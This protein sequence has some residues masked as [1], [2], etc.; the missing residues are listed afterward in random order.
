MP[1]AISHPFGPVWDVNSRVLVLGTFPSAASREQGFYYGHPRNR[2]WLVLA[3]VFNS[4]LP[5]DV[6]EKTSLLL[7]SGVAL[8]D[9]LVSCEIEGSSDASIKN[10]VP[11]DI[12]GLAS[13][14]GIT[15]VLLNGQKAGALYEKH[16]APGI[17]IP[18]FRLPSTSPANAAWSHERLA[19]EWGQRLRY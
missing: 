8:W 1:S 11:N 5:S 12:A 3:S 10:P 9:V 4:P 19:E 14:S 17:S 13:K 16:C 6:G 18:H 2:F 7:N 15:K